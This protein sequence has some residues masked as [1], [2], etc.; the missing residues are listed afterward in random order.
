MANHK[1]GEKVTLTAKDSKDNVILFVQDAEITGII[2]DDA[3]IYE[4]LFID[5]EADKKFGDGI[6]LKNVE[7]VVHP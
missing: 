6:V 7:I 4:Y 5:I 1:I 2:N 3:L